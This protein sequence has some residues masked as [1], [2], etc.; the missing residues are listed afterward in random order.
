LNS[1]INKQIPFAS[2][3]AQKPVPCD[4]PMAAVMSG[5]ANAAAKLRKNR[6]RKIINANS[7]HGSFAQERDIYVQKMSAKVDAAGRSIESLFDQINEAEVQCRTLREYFGENISVVE[8]HRIFSTLKTFMDLLAQSKRTYEKLYGRVVVV[9][10]ERRSSSFSDDCSSSSGDKEFE[11]RMWA[12]ESHVATRFGPGIVEA[13][14]VREHVYMVRLNWGVA[15]LRQDSIIDVNCIVRTPYG[16]G[17][18]VA[19]ENHHEGQQTKTFYQVDLIWG[20]VLL[21]PKSIFS[22]HHNERDDT[23]SLS[24]PDD[25]DSGELRLSFDNS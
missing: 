20:Y 17:R 15:F 19:I 24:F 25:E 5:I 12:V 9:K 8:S 3:V 1:N 21:R 16:H 10:N 23:A 11:T 14:R 18:V 4:N 2:N 22:I 6:T 13:L 7:F